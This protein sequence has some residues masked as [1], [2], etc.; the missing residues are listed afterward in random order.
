MMHPPAHK[1]FSLVETLVAI[2]LLAV[3]L[4]GPFIAVRNALTGSYIARDQLI[5]SMLAQ[6]GMEYLRSIRDNNY[7]ASPQR[8]WLDG[9]SAAARDACFGASPSGVCTV[10]PTRGDFHGDSSGMQEYASVSAAPVLKLSST[11]LYNQQPATATNVDTQFKRTVVMQ[12]LSATEVRI[13]I[14]VSWSRSGQSYSTV[15]TDV[16]RDWL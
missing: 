13:T 3:A 11:N 4:V 1:G 6:E 15:V 16:L 9:F 14:T 10:D 8:D 2:T 5:A 12:S 7:L